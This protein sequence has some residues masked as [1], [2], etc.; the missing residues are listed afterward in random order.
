MQIATISC[1]PHRATDHKMLGEAGGQRYEHII[2]AAVKQVH[3]ED[4][5]AELEANA[6]HVVSQAVNKVWHDPAELNKYF[7][8]HMDGKHW[9]CTFCHQKC[10]TIKCRDFCHKKFCGND[11]EKIL[12]AKNSIGRVGLAPGMPVI[13]QYANAVQKANAALYSAET[14]TTDEEFREA[15]NGLEDVLNTQKEDYNHFNDQAQYADAVD[16]S[17]YP[18]E[19]EKKAIDDQNYHA[20]KAEAD[21]A[22]EMAKDDEKESNKEANANESFTQASEATKEADEALGEKDNLMKGLQTDIQAEDETLNAAAGDGSPG[23]GGENDRPAMTQVSNVAAEV[24]ALGV[25]VK[26]AKEEATNSNSK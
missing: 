18:D 5:K 14:A 16:A 15:K 22:T 4:R 3:Q 6:H 8:E 24:E 17:A 12:A 9:H 25:K 7:D 21:H 26:A 19:R 13:P 2:A 20:E 11:Y 1:L 23:G 10:K